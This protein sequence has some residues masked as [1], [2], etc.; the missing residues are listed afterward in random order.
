MKDATGK[1]R[2]DADQTNLVSG[3]IL[4]DVTHCTRHADSPREPRP[5]SLCVLEEGAL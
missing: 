1:Q 5:L 4:P 3:T 2:E